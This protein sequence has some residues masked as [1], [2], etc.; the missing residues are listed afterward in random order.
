MIFLD[1]S[2]KTSIFGAWVV[3]YHS[4]SIVEDWLLDIIVAGYYFEVRV[5]WAQQKVKVNV[6]CCWH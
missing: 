6:N 3:P 4:S 5:E 1:V 2:Q